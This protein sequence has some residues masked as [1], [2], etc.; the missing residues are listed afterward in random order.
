ME[1]TERSVPFT[2][3]ILESRLR[4]NEALLL[5]CGFDGLEELL[6]KSV[7]LLEWAVEVAADNDQIARFSKVNNQVTTEQDM[8]F[9]EE[10]RAYAKRHGAESIRR[11]L[12]GP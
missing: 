2:V 6:N 3:E 4:R 10:V 5:I 12:R 9:L 1:Q 8:P 7:A 11:L